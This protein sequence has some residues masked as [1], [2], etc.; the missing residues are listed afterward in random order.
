MDIAR[1]NNRNNFLLHEIP[2][3][4]PDSLKYLDFWRLQKKFIIEG[5]WAQDTKDENEKGMWRFMP[6]QLYFYV[7]FCKILH[8]P[9][10]SAKTA[11]RKKIRPNLDD[12]DWDF[13]YKYME[14]KGFSGFEG[15]TKFTCNR[16]YI[17]EGKDERG[18]KYI[19]TRDYI[20]KLFDQPLGLPLYENEAKNGML[21]GSRGIGKSYWLA[22]G[23]ILHGII[24]DGAI[25]YDEESIKNPA[26]IEIFVGAAIAAK[27]SDL[28]SKT[29]MGMINLPG[30]WKEG[31]DEEIPPPFYKKMAGNLLPNNIKNPWRHEYDKKI[32]GEWKKA[33]SGSNVKHGIFTTE[34]PEAAAGGRY[35]LIVVEE[36]GL[37]FNVLSVHGGNDAAQF[38]EYKMGSSWY[39]GT[40]GNIEKII[41]SEIMF[42]DPEGFNMLEFD[43]IWEGMG[44]ICYFIPATYANR[45]F[46]DEEGNTKVQEA[47]D[48]YLKRREEKKKAKSSSALDLEMMN[49]PIIPSEMFINK[50]NNKFPIADLKQTLASLLT[51]DKALAASWKGEFSIEEDG[52]PKWNNKDIRPIREFPLK[53]GDNMEGC[54][55]IYQMPLIDNEGNIPNGRYIASLD[56]ID[57][58]ENKDASR[59]L[60]SAWIYDTFLDK[61]VAEYTSRTKFAKD[62]YEQLRR[63]L[64][65]YNSRMLYENQKKGI[66]AYFEQKN[67]LWI[68]EDTPEILRDIDMQ[69]IS[70][71]GNRSKGVYTTPAIIRWGIDLYAQWLM[72]QAVGKPDGVTNAHTLK[73]VGLIR[74]SIIYSKDINTD[75]ISSIIIL[76]IYRESKLK[77]VD[78]LKKASQ[79]YDI[80]KDKF[81]D[82]HFQ[83]REKLY[84]N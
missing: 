21:L 51:S 65:F 48:Y 66:F 38:I 46:K 26:Q 42:R 25:I 57:D 10:G 68:L 70:I 71:T 14:S 72:T 28:L 19:P 36:V 80:A 61:I 7:N 47:T 58:D 54:W 69:K 78:K 49:Y 60:Q 52:K 32:G 83:R 6:P 45:R 50:A 84:G 18:R 17:E 8:K 73:S 35:V 29:T 4:H 11:P 79:T 41:E 20:N 30:A 34:N 53:K 76:M 9:E 44:K 23:C 39:I 40:G 15:D 56:P 24:T 27:S 55:E 33:G 12:I 59:S 5:K 2:V 67:C 82:K 75:R 81:W 64:I 74:E 3:L 22:D 16:D 37:M 62:Y 77:Y 31:T 13:F 43:D 1:I 63:G